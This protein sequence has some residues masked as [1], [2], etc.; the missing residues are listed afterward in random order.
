MTPDQLERALAAVDPEFE[1]A[2]ARALEDDPGAL[3]AFLRQEG[4]FG[5]SEG[6]EAPSLT[7]PEEM[8]LSIIE[9]TGTA[10]STAELQERIERDHREALAAYESFR[11]RPWVSEKVN[12][13]ARK[14]YVGKYREGREVKYTPDPTEAVRRWALHNDMFGSELSLADVDEIVAETGMRPATVRRAVRILAGE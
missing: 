13:L 9:E 2:L 5:P 12:S 3:E 1:A 7:E 6:T 14:G 11:H 4:Y 8:L 10:A